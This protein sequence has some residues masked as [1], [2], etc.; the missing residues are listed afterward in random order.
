MEKINIVGDEELFKMLTSFYNISQLYYQEIP[1]KYKDK[2]IILKKQKSSK[3][4]FKIMDIL[5]E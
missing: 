5:G 4:K 3:I 2:L 1:D